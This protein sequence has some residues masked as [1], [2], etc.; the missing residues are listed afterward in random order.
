MILESYPRSN[1]WYS[2]TS[3]SGHLINHGT[4]L[5]RPVDA[6]PIL[7]NFNVNNFIK[8]ATSLIKPILKSPKGGLIN[9]VL[10]YLYIFCLTIMHCLLILLMFQSSINHNRNRYVNHICLSFALLLLIR[11][12]QCNGF[13]MCLLQIV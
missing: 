5:I 6:R 12:C 13:N 4:L 9:E 10:L 7:V 8:T 2:R 11:K 3:V 1:Y